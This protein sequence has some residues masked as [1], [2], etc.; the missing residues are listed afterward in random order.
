MI[1]PWSP[2]RARTIG[3]PWMPRSTRIGKR[4]Q[5][6]PEAK[7]REPVAKETRVSR[8]DPQAVTWCVTASRRASFL[9]TGRLM[10][11]SASS[12]T[13]HATP[14]NVHDSIVSLDRLDRQR[15]RFGFDVGAVGLDA[16]Y[17]TSGIA[18][19]LEERG[20]PGVIGYRR[21]TPLRPGMMARKL[22]QA[23]ADGYRC[24]QGQLLTYATPRLTGAHFAAGNFWFFPTS[25][26]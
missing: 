23:A 4:R 13:L 17:T 1:W 6:G 22:F 18:K 14:A 25:F 26:A 9:T 11:G 19:G 15:E 20:I 3:M 16:G 21:P 7:P 24:P 5:A 12:P 2:I 10:P 8:T